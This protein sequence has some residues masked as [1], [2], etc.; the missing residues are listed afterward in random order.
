MGRHRKMVSGYEYI[1]QEMAEL[2]SEEGF[3]DAEYVFLDP[4]LWYG[5]VSVTRADD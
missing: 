3:K 5:I 1:L 4:E 2:L